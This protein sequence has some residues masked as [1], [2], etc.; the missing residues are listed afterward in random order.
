MRDGLPPTENTIALD[1]TSIVEPS[2]D[3]IIAIRGYFGQNQLIEQFGL[4]LPE[5]VGELP[6]L[7]IGAVREIQ[8]IYS[9]GGTPS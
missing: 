6:D 5:I 1:G 3:G 9:A 7:A 2:S 8:R 4:T